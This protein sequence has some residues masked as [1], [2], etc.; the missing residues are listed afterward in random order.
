MA[1]TILNLLCVYS[2]LDIFYS[3]TSKYFVPIKILT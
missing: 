1:K 2:L 3:N